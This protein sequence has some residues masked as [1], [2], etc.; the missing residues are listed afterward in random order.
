MGGSPPSSLHIFETLPAEFTF[1]KL[2]LMEL[3][4]VFLGHEVVKHMLKLYG[5]VF[6]KKKLKINL[7]L[8][9]LFIILSPHFSDIS[10]HCVVEGTFLLKQTW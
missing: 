9:V 4:P 6:D 10:Q 2:F 8:S 7:L 5:L 1:Q 3:N